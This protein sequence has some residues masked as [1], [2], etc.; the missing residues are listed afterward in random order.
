MSGLLDVASVLVPHAL[1]LDAHSHLR[2]AGLQGLEGL[3]LWAGVKD[4]H[5]FRVTH[6]VIPK[7]HGLRTSAGVSVSIGPDELHR[8]NVWLFE[9]KL[10]L[11]AQLHSHPTDAY[12][13]DTDDAFPIATTVG[14]LS[15]VIPD[16][17]RR[18]FALP[19]CAIYR[20][21]ATAVWE[22]LSAWEVLSLIELQH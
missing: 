10:T 6:T 1:A 13:S 22:K 14:S 18:P 15:L 17:A 12:H 16:F 20:L 19:D 11:I 4:G 21:S 9:N 2:T 8:L 5:V 7:Q 3:A